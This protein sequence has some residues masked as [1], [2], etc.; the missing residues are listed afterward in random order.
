MILRRL[1]VL[2]PALLSVAAL[3]ASAQHSTGSILL[4]QLGLQPQSAPSAGA[5]A[6]NDPSVSPGTSFL[7]GLEAKFAKATAQGGGQAFASF[8]AGDAVTLA[9]GKA[10]VIGQA[11]I[12]QQAMQRKRGVLASAPAKYD[13]LLQSEI[14]TSSARRQLRFTAGA[15]F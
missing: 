1:V 13:A 5:S 14:V 10:P 3:S 15:I 7:Y 2:L 12:A 9:N 4:A 8:F 11:A 6:L